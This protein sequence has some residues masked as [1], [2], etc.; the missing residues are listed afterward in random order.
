MTEKDG[1]TFLGWSREKLSTDDLYKDCETV[2]ELSY[3]DGET[4]VLYAQWGKERLFDI[5]FYEW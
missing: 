1:Y 4:V 5:I 3:V 2:T